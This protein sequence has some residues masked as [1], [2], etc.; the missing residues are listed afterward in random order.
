M[1]K[2]KLNK[3]FNLLKNKNTLLLVGL[4]VFWWAFLNDVDVSNSDVFH[5]RD[6]DGLGDEEE[7]MY[8]TDVDN[9][10]TDGDGYRDGVEVESGYDPLIPAPGDKIFFKNETEVQAET[11][12]ELPNLTD[13][14]FEKLEQEKGDEL[15]LLNDY[16]A[17]P[18]DFEDEQERGELNELSLTS[19]ELQNFLEQ[20]AKGAG[21]AFEMEL[22]SEDEII[23]LEEPTG[24][25]KRVEEKEKNQIEKYL[26]QVFYVMSVNKPFA[27]ESQMLLPQLGAGYISEI[28][29]AVQL[30]R[31]SQLT[32]LK[33][34]AQKTYEE[35]LKIETPY[36]LKD[37]HL[38][39]LS[40]INYLTEDIDEEKLIDQQDPMTMALY[41]GKL[42]AALIEG[43][44][45]KGEIEEILEE[46]EIE[47][48]NSESLEG[49]F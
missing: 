38:E 27:V 31:V 34:K 35:C 46:Y 5:D 24:S 29:G 3:F 40:I 25:D 48:F 39:T 4:L 10:D 21:L 2:T 13:D 43:E 37:I 41:V 7:Y 11:G 8:G 16:Y 17:N 22:I 30:G 44:L 33:D 1:K 28:S 49:I 9:P 12:E 47:I 14:F 18:E 36:K 23:V 15:N 26:T 45:L 6:Q 42:Q 32:D 19:E 20:T